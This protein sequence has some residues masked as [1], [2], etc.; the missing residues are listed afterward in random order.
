M[1]SLAL[2]AHL[3]RRER[4]WV[5]DVA[6]RCRVERGQEWVGGVAG[7]RASLSLC[8]SRVSQEH[9]APSVLEGLLACP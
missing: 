3:D 5:Q 7:L 9:L 6:Q 4:R 8:C 1:A 2:R